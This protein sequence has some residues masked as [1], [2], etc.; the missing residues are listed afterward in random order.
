MNTTTPSEGLDRDDPLDGS[1]PT[2][3]GARGTDGPE[4]PTARPR[5]GASWITPILL[6]ALIVAVL[7]AS[8]CGDHDDDDVICF[9]DDDAFDDD[10]C[11]PVDDDAFDDDFDDAVGAA[12]ALLPGVVGLA[13]VDFRL[14][15]TDEEGFHPYRWIR[16]I[17]GIGL[18]AS[19]G[20]RIYGPDDLAKFSRRVIAENPELIGLEEGDGGFVN[21][22]VTATPNEVAVRFEQVL[23][24][25]TVPDASLTFRFDGTGVLR[26]IENRSRPGWIWPR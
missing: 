4:L 21:P 10:D 20:E 18:F 2:D 7:P 9:V 1:I 16:G 24:G 19:D 26:E 8:R 23:E 6:F 14:E 22:T 17:E 11:I 3:V 13:L 5:T 12:P 25:R 15:R